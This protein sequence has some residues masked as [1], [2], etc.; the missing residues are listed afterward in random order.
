MKAIEDFR[1]GDAILSRDEWDASAD[2]TVQY[3]EEV[4][5]T[6]GRLLNVHAGGQVIGTTAE[7]PFWVVGR[8][9]TAALELQS[10]DLLLGHD[11][12]TVVVE[13][14]F[15]TGET[16]PVYNL[17]VS[18]HHTYFVG[19]DEWDWS[20]WAH[21]SYT[22]VVSTAR[23]VMFATQRAALT[24]AKNIGGISKSLQPKLIY[25]FVDGT[26]GLGTTTE[27][28]IKVITISAQAAGFETGLWMEFFVPGIGYRYIINHLRPAEAAGQKLGVGHYHIGKPK[29]E[30]IMARLIPT[31]KIRNRYENMF[32]EVKWEHIAYERK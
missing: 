9:W 4:F 2:V 31:D 14:V 21:N 1:V 7:H 23:I 11:G 8:G 12:Q 10:G 15:D 30:G 16:V 13:E 27:H 25:R 3:V 20:V 5:R 6:T 18:E 24:M 26:T 19:R 29:E 22:E 28:G 17:R 32:N